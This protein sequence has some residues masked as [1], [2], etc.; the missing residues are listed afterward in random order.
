MRLSTTFSCEPRNASSPVNRYVVPDAPRESRVLPKSRTSTPPSTEAFGVAGPGVDLVARTIVRVEESRAGME[1]DSTERQIGCRAVSLVDPPFGSI[2]REVH[3]IELRRP[4]Q[5]A[6]ARTKPPIGPG[7]EGRR[8]ILLRVLHGV[9][10]VGVDADVLDRDGRRDG[11]RPEMP[12]GLRP[13]VRLLRARVDGGDEDQRQDCGTNEIHLG[14]AATPWR[15][16]P[17][18]ASVR[19]GDRSGESG[20]AGKGPLHRRR[21]GRR[22]LPDRSAS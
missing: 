4:C 18:A 6:R 16:R 15:P 9:E 2:L 5:P 22:R 17:G 20:R 19:T 10:D 11:E 13:R 14:S 21:P 8:E 1:P 12:A 3:E 7:A